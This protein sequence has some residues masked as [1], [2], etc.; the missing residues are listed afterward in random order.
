MDKSKVLSKEIVKE[1]KSKQFAAAVADQ[2]AED[3]EREYMEMWYSYLKSKKSFED[4]LT[5][6]ERLDCVIANK[7]VA[8]NANLLKDRN[9]THEEMAL[10]KELEDLKKS[11]EQEIQKFNKEMEDLSDKYQQLEQIFDENSLRQEID[12]ITEKNIAFETDILEFK[13]KLS[14]INE[15]IFNFKGYDVPVDVKQLTA[16]VNEESLKV[17]GDLLENEKKYRELKKQIEYLEG[18][19]NEFS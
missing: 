13:E 15:D 4:H 14:Q 9:Y 19:I 2:E 16:E 7:M 18:K 12:K 3:A 11:S 1:L 6:K 5:E 10:L 8:I 17:Y